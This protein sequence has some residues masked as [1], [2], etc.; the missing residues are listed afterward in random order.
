M[1]RLIHG[2]SRCSG[3]TRTDPKCVMPVTRECRLPAPYAG[4]SPSR[5]DQGTAVVAVVVAGDGVVVGV[6]VGLLLGVVVGVVVGGVV[7]GE[8]PVSP[9][10]LM[11][12]LPFISIHGAVVVP[13]ELLAML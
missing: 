2:C 12:Q 1:H 9:L 11:Y 10:M 5:S 6:V 4:D 3:R 7:V 13:L 8:V